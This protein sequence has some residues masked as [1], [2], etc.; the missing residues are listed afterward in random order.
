[1]EQHRGDAALTLILI[2]KA[3][4]WAVIAG[5]TGSPDRCGMKYVPPLASKQNV[6]DALKNTTFSVTLIKNS[7][8]KTGMF[9]RIK[10]RRTKQL[11]G[12]GSN[13]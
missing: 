2:I 13:I 3:G 5:M 1:M 6:Q 9:A 8:S 10:G 7:C 11:G 12:G 4:D